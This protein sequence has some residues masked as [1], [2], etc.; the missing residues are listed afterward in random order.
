MNLKVRITLL[1]LSTALAVGL[2][3]AAW[4][5][6]RLH[7][8]LFQDLAD[9]GSSISM[10]LA[11][12]LITHLV[13]RDPVSV[14]HG[15]RRLSSGSNDIAYVY[16][17]DF[18][19]TVFGHSFDGGFPPG[20]LVQ[21]SESGQA[22]VPGQRET[23]FQ[24]RDILE[25][26]RPLVG[27]MPARITIG[28]E[29]EL[30]DRQIHQ[31]ALL[32]L[33]V[34]LLIGFMVALLG[35]I[36]A[37]RVTQPIEILAEQIGRYGRG[38][39]VSAEALGRLGGS[40]E[41][42]LLAHRFGDMIRERQQSEIELNQIEQTLDNT[43]D[44][45]FMFY[46]DTLKFFYANRGALQQVGYSRNELLEMTPLDIKPGYEERGFRALIQPLL[47]GQRNS[48]TFET[49]HRHK[50]GRT[51]PVEIFLQYMAEGEPPHFL[52][53]VRD[54]SER[55]QAEAELTQI[56][57]TLDNTLDAVFMFDPQ[58][59]KFFYANRG[60]LQQL[61]YSA[62]ELLD[63][64]P[65]DIEPD[66]DEAGFRG[67][68]APLLDGTQDSLTLET[69]HR[70]KTGQD[71]PVEIFLQYM[72][73]GET[74]HFLA[75]V[76]DIS[77]RRR[78]E[79]ALQASS[80]Q[81]RSVVTAAPLVLWSW[82]K[83]GVFTLSEGSGLA[84]LG[85][86]PGEVVG[87]SVFDVYSGAPELVAAAKRSLTGETFVE[88][89]EVGGRVWEAHYQPWHDGRGE[90]IG[91][92]GV[93]LD[94]TDRQQTERQLRD[95]RNFSKAVLDNAGA[96][97]LVLDRHGRILEFNRACEQLSGYRFEEV[98]GQF[99]WDLLLL[100]DER[101]AVREQA[102]DALAHS[103]QT[104]SGSYTNHWLT[105]DGQSRLI[106]WNNTVLLDDTGQLDYL[107]SIGVDITEQQRAEEARERR[108]AL[109]VQVAEGIRGEAAGDFLHDLTRTLAETLQTDYAFI[110]AYEPEPE[111]RMRT[112]S[113]FGKG[114]RQPDFEYPMRGT[115]CEQVLQGKDCVYP[116]GVCERFPEDP[117]LATMGIDAYI[118]SPVVDS[119]STLVGVL[120]VLHGGPIEEPQLVEQIVRIFASRAGAELERQR[121]Q[122][123]LQESEALLREAQA[124]AHL[125]NWNLDLTSGEAIWSDEEYRLLG[126][127]PGAVEPSVD[128][129]MQAVHPDDRDPVKAE[130]QRA[131]DPAE[132]RP[133]H[134]EHRVTVNGDERIVEQRGRVTFDDTGR[135][136]RMFGTTMDVTERKQAERSLQQL[137]DQLEQRVRERTTQLADTNSQLRETLQTLQLAQD[138]LVRSEKLASLGSLVA[139]VAHE[140]NTPLGNSVTVS[141]TLQEWLRDFRREL[142]GDTLRRSTVDGFVQQAEQATQLLVRNLARAAELI[143]DF[144]Q[145]AVDQT[146]AQR[147]GF[148]LERV[149]TEVIETLQPQFKKTPH[150]VHTTIPHGI[151]LDSYPG[152]LGQVI[153]NLTLNA[154]VHGFSDDMRGE[155]RV[156]AREIDGDR[157]ELLISDNGRGIPADHL[158]KVFDPFFTTRMG[159]GGSGLG[160]HIVY[161]LV[162]RVLGGSIA[163]ESPPQGGTRV[164]LRLPRIAPQGGDNGAASVG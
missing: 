13:E 32:V 36:I 37:R 114:Q 26:S 18:D 134:A 121:Q 57:E 73:R 133:Y 51:T 87:K 161:T 50:S 152:P 106:T 124:L 33:A 110:A 162:T 125:G 158:S 94:I 159:Q 69:V 105:R 72:A 43:H 101:D 131:M 39:P 78:A 63:M 74:P 113:V 148:D 103:P 143:A 31:T 24:D 112:L 104:L 146:S 160:L 59:L 155:V 52:A 136:L 138:E 123:A 142:S 8:V 99:A 140:L 38:E 157:V 107:V 118:G 30:I 56:K 6:A 120:A 156:Q 19:G 20:L 88:T 149:I 108:E 80:L 151:Q 27:R 147:R 53:M 42:E 5:S 127:E 96:L 164:T 47:A 79:A 154:L 117:D 109:I 92:I 45:V 64:T 128:H 9:R 44:A 15:L 84:R 2:G 91:T 4:T 29:T 89:S 11:E 16:V 40:P 93:A 97:I 22:G 122:S 163:I 66:Y 21:F 81:L 48:L 25:I 65:V 116:S 126:Y 28:M 130:M 153:T 150:Q 75:M 98:N 67:I 83:N 85:L 12:T 17:T 71:I 34:S 60:A 61:G 86:A 115:P 41:T 1:I 137:N 62:D 102:F 132:T 119:Q 135:A 10:A 3:S 90:L 111:P 129:F 144:K 55:K 139:G 145:V 46:P 35:S 14:I 82:D 76:R 70:T 23:R 58:S 141:T 77:E 49:V 95:E 68:L 54:I 100:P 7:D